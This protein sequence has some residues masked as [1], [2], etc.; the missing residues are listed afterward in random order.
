MVRTRGT[1]G[2][3]GSGS[4]TLQER[5]LQVY[6]SGNRGSPGTSLHG[7]S[8]QKVQMVYFLF[9]VENGRR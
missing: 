9:K 5:D 1:P 8:R 4:P 7:W 6:R 2:S 3:E